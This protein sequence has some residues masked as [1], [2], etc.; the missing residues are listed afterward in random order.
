V[1]EF[2]KGLKRVE[3]WNRK[4]LKEYEVILAL[5]EEIREF[6]LEVELIK[7]ARSFPLPSLSFIDSSHKALT[8]TYLGEV[9]YGLVVAGYRTGTRNGGFSDFFLN[10]SEADLISS[11]DDIGMLISNIA[12]V[13]E[14]LHASRT[15]E[16][17]F[18]PVMDGSP[19]TFVR[20]VEYLKE[21][22]FYCESPVL[23]SYLDAMD[24]VESSLLQVLENGIFLP[25]RTG[26]KDFA[27]FLVERGF[28]GEERVKAGIT[29]Y[30]LLQ[31][32]LE[33]GEYIVLPSSVSSKDYKDY[34]KAGKR[35]KVVYFKGISGRIH[36]GEATYVDWI[37]Y[38]FPTFVKDGENIFAYMVDRY[39]KRYLD[40]LSNSVIS[41][42]E[43]RV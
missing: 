38:L 33:A 16:E 6:L 14:V 42:G 26:R 2:L 21:R 40:Y 4:T 34:W 8:K 11:D 24:E 30:K 1:K 32:A 12:L 13:E 3:E 31:F 39:A 23:H 28:I 43:Y 18:T 15:L 29:D 20:A 10:L 36:R 5:G 35:M 22:E 41:L 19:L 9:L 37:D 17:G 27:R 7:K 25:K